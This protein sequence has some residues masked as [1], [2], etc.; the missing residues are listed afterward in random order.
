MSKI[1]GIDLGTT[2]SVVA[3]MEGAEPHVIANA[4]GHRLTPSVVAFTEKERLVGVTAKR[5]SITNPRNTIFS[6][7]R[8]MGRRHSE[9]ADEEKM[10]PYKIVGG[11]EELV[12][13]E[14]R[15]K[16]YT[17]PEI[18]AMILQS[19]KET[20]EAYLGEKVD[21]A[22]I[23]VPAYFN[24]SQR[25]ATKDAGT[26]AGLKVERIL[27]EPTAAA[28]AYGLKEK[29]SGA[30][31]AVFDLGG[32]T[33]DISILEVDEGFFKVL[34]TNGDTHLGGDNFD[35]ILMDSIAD[36]FKKENGID[37]RKD[38]MALQRLKEA[39]EKAKCEL[40]TKTVTDI[41]LPFITAD[42]SGPKHLQMELTRAR[43]E[44]LLEDEFQRVRKPCELAMNDAGM[45]PEQIDEVVLVG[46]ATRTPRVQQ[47]AK[48]LFRREP[49]RSVNP[50]EVVAL[51][52]AIQAGIL[53]GNQQ[54]NEVLLLDVTPLSLGIETLGGV[55]TRL[56]ERNTTIP[57]TKK[58]VFSTAADSQP[59][60][61]IKVYQGEREM[62]RDNRLLGSFLLDGIPPAPRGVPQ[63]EVT[64]DIDANGILNVSAKDLGT[65]KAKSIKITSSSGLSKDEVEKMRKDAELHASEDKSKKELATFKNDAD[66]AVYRTEKLLKEHADAIGE[67]ERSR[68]DSILDRLKSARDKEDAAG[69]K[70]ILSEL[71][72]ASQELGKAIYEKAARSGAGAAGGEE[73]GPE[74]GEKAAKGKKKGAK[75]EGDETIIDADYEVKD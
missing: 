8:F 23:T 4:D 29:R 39:A 55:M 35:Q 54:L 64:F 48:D 9:V 22:V 62:A 51:G 43:L 59:A 56:I 27:N 70:K 24:D 2:N 13:V 47:I 66:N 26:I 71:E 61:D 50:D 14:I 52:A 74:E 45:K 68:I 73:S 41:S 15:G 18:S 31:V 19:L 75:G 25:Q 36:E 17:P 57:T 42:Q 37:L 16:Q 63:I 7:K 46:G 28:L 33:F 10:V 30:K 72:E 34:S 5:Q 69:M 44:Q 21:R 6:I 11:P 1:I 12:K 49:N 3:V 58:E 32:G 60:V 53:Q 67:K 38:Q 40:S 20:A 65:G